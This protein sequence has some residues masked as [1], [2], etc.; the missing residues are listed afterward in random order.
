DRYQPGGETAWTVRPPTCGRS[1][2]HDAERVCQRVP[3]ESGAAQVQ[4]AERGHERRQ[5]RLPDRIRMKEVERPERAE[6]CRM[7]MRIGDDPR[8][9]G[10][11]GTV[12]A[13]RHERARAQRG[14][15]RGRTRPDA[16][17]GQSGAAPPAE[18]PGAERDRADED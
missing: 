8:D 12:H 3:G 18:K 13:W 5:G 6:S 17:A 14:E 16:R 2:S 4:I 1:E 11:H 9:G 15:D 7:S 10:V